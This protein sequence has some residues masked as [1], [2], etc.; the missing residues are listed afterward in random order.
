MPAS[1][2]E[3]VKVGLDL[4]GRLK[5]MVAIPRVVTLERQLSASLTDLMGHVGIHGRVGVRSFEASDDR[6]VRV[7]VEGREVPYPSSLLWRTWISLAGALDVPLP[8]PADGAEAPD[9]WLHAWMD[10][11][12]GERVGP[13]GFGIVDYLCA[14]VTA[15]VA[16]RPGCLLPELPSGWKSASGGLVTTLLDLGVSVQNRTC[17]EAAAEIGTT[18]RL[19]DADVAEAAFAEL[20]PYRL[21]LRA[22]ELALAPALPGAHSVSEDAINE[23][24]GQLFKLFFGMR[25]VWAPRVEFEPEPDPESLAVTVR[26]NDRLG[27][28]AALLPADRLLVAAP[29]DEVRAGG[30]DGAPA[31]NPL[32][33]DRATMVALADRPRLTADPIEPYE[34]LGMIVFRAL[35]DDAPGLVCLRHVER[36]LMLVGQLYDDLVQS[37]LE[38]LSIYDLTRVLR[39]LVRDGVSIRNMRAI[40]DRLLCYHALAVPSLE[41]TVLTEGLALPLGD[42]RLE[43]APDAAQLLAFLRLGLP[44]E[45]GG[46]WNGQAPVLAAR[47]APA[48]ERRLNEPDHQ[49]VDGREAELLRDQAIAAIPHVHAVVTS[50][51]A[52]AELSALLDPVLESISVVAEP[53][54]NGTQ[55]VDV[56]TLEAAEV[57]A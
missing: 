8:E 32:T 2:I 43:S 46:A 51:Q 13:D 28:P 22:S 4:G 3:P 23:T 26:V 35:Q 30:I 10:R 52:R 53:E 11:H 29:L 17:I 7:R 12:D 44:G 48:L 21:A 49:P 34:V 25:G 57:P 40:L 41:D 31:I 14:L 54:L 56:V 15:I 38:R 27:L 19:P 39:A 55:T 16:R 5:P 24:L 18:L 42:P 9:A 6:A 50:V 1:S 33:G 20:R 45:I 47:L 36:S 37:A